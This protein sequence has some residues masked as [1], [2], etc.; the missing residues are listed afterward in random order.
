MEAEA[1][2]APGAVRRRW[3][4][5]VSVAAENTPL[6]LLVPK[7]DVHGLGFDPLKGAEDFRRIK[8][9]ARA[10]ARPGAGSGEAGKK[11]RRGIAFGSG[12]G[13]AC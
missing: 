9:A 13:T 11:R 10:A 6:H 3:G 7:T 5:H 8:E 12:K 1:E 4:Q 2:S